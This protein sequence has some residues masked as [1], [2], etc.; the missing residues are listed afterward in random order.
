MRA[1]KRQKVP[2]IMLERQKLSFKNV[3]VCVFSGGGYP[4]NAARIYASTMF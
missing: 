2:G 4:T 3:G 1:S